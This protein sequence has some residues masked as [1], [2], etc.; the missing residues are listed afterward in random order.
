MKINLVFSSRRLYH[1]TTHDVV[2]KVL[3]PMKLA[4]ELVGVAA[5][6]VPRQL[7]GGTAVPHHQ[8][9]L[10]ALLHCSAGDVLVSDRVRRAGRLAESRQQNHRK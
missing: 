2:T 5:G 10:P 3:P 4:Y 1:L 7:P 9:V 6:V 8:P